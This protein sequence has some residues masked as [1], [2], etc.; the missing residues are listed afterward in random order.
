VNQDEKIWCAVLI[1]HGLPPG[2]TAILVAPAGTEVQP[3]PFQ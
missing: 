1:T 2:A 3:L